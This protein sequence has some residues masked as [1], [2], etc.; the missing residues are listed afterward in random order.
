MPEEDFKWMR[1]CLE[2]HPLIGEQGAPPCARA[3]A[4][5]RALRASAHA[6]APAPAQSGS[7]RPKV[8]SSRSTARSAD[9]HACV[10]P[11]VG[12]PRLCSQPLTCCCRT[13]QGVAVLRRDQRFECLVVRRAPPPPVLTGHVSSLLPY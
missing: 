3:R 8:S 6:P 2:H 5:P 13:W 4:P 7:R 9:T 11:K 10:E 12:V 1:T